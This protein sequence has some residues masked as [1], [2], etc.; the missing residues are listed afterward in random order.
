MYTDKFVEKQTP[1]HFASTVPRCVELIGDRSAMYM[2]LKMRESSAIAENENFAHHVWRSN[3]SCF[4][5]DRKLFRCG[6]ARSRMLGRVRVAV[7]VHVPAACSAG[8]PCSQNV[9]VQSKW[10]IV[11]TNLGAMLSWQARRGFSF[12][13]V[14]WHHSQWSRLDNQGCLIWCSFQATCVD[15]THAT[16]HEAGHGK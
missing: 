12:P 6:A 15:T 3:G 13:Y 9:I 7:H 4:L 11:T 10:R 2:E 16:I 1:I 14:L 5:R 8:F